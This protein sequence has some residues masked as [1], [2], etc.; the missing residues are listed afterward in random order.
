MFRSVIH[1]RD[2]WLKPGGKLLPSSVDIMLAP[3]DD[4]ELF[5]EHGPG[6]WKKS[7]IHGIDFSCFTE[8]ELQMG[9]TN[10]LLVPDKFL[11]A[12]GKSIHH[13]KTDKAHPED[14]WCSGTVEYEIQRD[15]ILNG[16]VGWFSTQLSPGV[17]LDTAPNCPRTH[18][19]QTY[20]PYH[21]ITVSAGQTVKIDY[22]MNE[23]FEKSRLM[24]MVLR[25]G[26]HE[27]K[28]IVD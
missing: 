16:I 11:L 9:H 2:T 20:F 24:E 8:K 14:E 7:N 1:V 15:G 5:H 28:Y 19:E 26:S 27:I 13:L 25:V 22:C 12:P 17:V 18:W 23:P 6:F 3:V 4:G 10:Q 21:P